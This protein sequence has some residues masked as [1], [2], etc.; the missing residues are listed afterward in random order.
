VRQTDTERAAHGGAYDPIG[1]ECGSRFAH[2]PPSAQRDVSTDCEE[3]GDAGPYLHRHFDTGTHGCAA[4][5]HRDTHVYRDGHCY[6]DAH[7]NGHGNCHKHSDVHAH[8]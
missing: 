1:A 5:V 4:H 3:R 6:G 8:R 7:A 2:A